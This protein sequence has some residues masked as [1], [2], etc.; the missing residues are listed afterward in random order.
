M[1]LNTIVSELRTYRYLMVV[2]FLYTALNNARGERAP[3]A[4]A[5]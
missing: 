4:F 5:G 2:S 3:T 1:N